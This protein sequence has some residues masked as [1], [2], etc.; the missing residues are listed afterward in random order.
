MIKTSTGDITAEYTYDGNGLRT[1]K[2][3]N[4][5]VTNHIWDGNQIILETSGTGEVTSKYVRGINLIYSEDGTGA[6]RRFF[7]YNGHGDVVQLTD[8][9]GSS[10]KSYDYDAFGNEKNPDAND[11][12]VFRYCGEYFDK[13]T[14]TIYLRARYYD[15][16]IGRFITEDSYWGKDS[17]PLSLNLYTYCRNNPI[18][19]I[20]PSGHAPAT[21]KYSDGKYGVLADN[22][23]NNAVISVFGAIPFGSNILQWIIDKGADIETISKDD[24]FS[25]IK[26]N[27]GNISDAL[28]LADRLNK[29]KILP[30]A[31]KNSG[32]A[33]S[34]VAGA[35]SSIITLF[36]VG[37]AIFG[38]S[39][40]INQ[41]TD[42]MYGSMIKS[43]TREGAV[44]KYTIYSGFVKKLV[45][46]GSITYKTTWSGSVKDLK[47]DWDKVNRTKVDL[48]LDTDLVQE[49]YK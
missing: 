1:S 45:D 32:K 46:N 13:E 28:S 10:V 19:F 44:A 17:D 43:D 22:K 20:D 48:G 34:K 38:D 6:N 3:I 30:E 47:I 23:W 39:A 25:S 27:L 11:T 15:P 9:S 40:E 26:G 5:I 37:S 24:M 29:V 41:I 7:L 12:N 36:D 2:N 42:R 18:M 8:A 21:F 4:G 31:I 49:L 14:G 35:V 33:V 16:M